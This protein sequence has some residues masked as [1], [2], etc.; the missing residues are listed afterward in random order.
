MLFISCKLLF[1]SHDELL[2]PFPITLPCEQVQS[3]KF[4]GFMVPGQSNACKNTLDKFS[5]DKQNGVI[6]TFYSMILCTMKVNVGNGN[7]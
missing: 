1:P 5:K 3:F 4:D 6:F 2:Y 7:R